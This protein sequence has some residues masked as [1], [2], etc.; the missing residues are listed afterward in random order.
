MF[1]VPIVRDRLRFVGGA[2]VEYSYIRLL[3]QSVTGVLACPGSGICA[4][5]KNNFDPLPAANLIYSPR[6][7]MNFRL[8]YSQS[9]SRPEFRELSPTQ[10]PSPRGLRPVNG[11][12]ALI[13]A[14][15]DNYD[16]RWEW[17][18]SPLELVSLSFFHKS[19]KNPIEQ[20]L[21]QQSSNFV[22]SFQNASDATLTGFEFEGRKNFGFIR[23]WLQGLSLS[24]NVAYINSTVNVPVA[25]GAQV[26][27]APSRALQ[28]QSPYVANATLEYAH[29]SWGTY[30]ILYQTAGPTLVT[31]PQVNPALPGIDL[32]S[33]NQLDAVA[34]L[35]IHPF[36]VPLTLKLGA[37]NLLN[38]SYE[39]TQGGEVQRLYT[40]GIKATLGLS[41]TY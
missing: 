11:N 2:R 13:E 31:A 34:I 19:I 26:Q 4:V 35:P 38:D 39:Q 29:P 41:Y 24:A 36:G 21:V 1:D 3:T 17:F 10:F 32:Q 33:R 6:D 15:I 7:D 28:G 20:A 18:F 37:E 23:P 14:N 40:R 27:T 9:V 16:A 30:R 12:P 25:T 22:I 8:G 5:N